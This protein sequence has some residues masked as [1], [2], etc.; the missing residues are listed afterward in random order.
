[1][2]EI[3]VTISAIQKRN[4]VGCHKKRT[5]FFAHRLEPHTC[6]HPYDRCR[7]RCPERNRE[8]IAERLHD[9]LIAKHLRIP[10]RRKPLPRVHAL[11]LVERKHHQCADRQIQKEENEGQIQP[12]KKLFHIILPSP[13]LSNFSISAMLITMKIIITRESPEPRFL[14]VGAGRKLLLDDVADQIDLAAAEH[15]GDRERRQRRHE[16]HRHPADDTRHTQRNDDL[17]QHR[18]LLCTQIIGRFP[19]SDDCR[20]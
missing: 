17:R 12:A 2:I 8:C 19:R 7:H 3:P 10:F 16:N 5:V 13:S 6:Q 11:A 9:L 15:I 14:P 18:P 1:M 20:S 4:I